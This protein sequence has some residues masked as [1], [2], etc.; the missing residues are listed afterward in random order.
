MVEASNNVEKSKDE[1][2]AVKAEVDALQ[3]RIDAI[4]NDQVP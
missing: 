4:N 3:A 2:H 1:K